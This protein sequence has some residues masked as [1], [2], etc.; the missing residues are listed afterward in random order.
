MTL[1]ASKDDPPVSAYSVTPHISDTVDLPRTTRCIWVGT[2]GN[3]RVLYAN[4]TEPVT[5]V[6]VQGQKSGAFR[7]I[8]STGTTASD[9]VGEV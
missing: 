3:V 1:Q 7:R 5:L 8:Y 9:I 4:D 6:G 2:L